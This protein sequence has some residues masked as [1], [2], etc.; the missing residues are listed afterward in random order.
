MIVLILIVISLSFIVLVGG[1]ITGIT[2]AIVKANKKS[3][4]TADNSL[5]CL[6]N[7]QLTPELREKVDSKV[8]KKNSTTIS[9][10]RILKEFSRFRRDVFDLSGPRINQKTVTMSLGGERLSFLRYIVKDKN[11]EYLAFPLMEGLLEVYKISDRLNIKVE[12]QL[13]ATVDIRAGEVLKTGGTVCGYLRFPQP[14][15]KS[16]LNIEG[17]GSYQ[18]EYKNTLFLNNRAACHILPNKA[19]L[20]KLS[21]YMASIKSNVVATVDFFSGLDE[22]LT[23]LEAQIALAIGLDIFYNYGGGTLAVSAEVVEERDCI[24]D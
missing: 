16:P 13:I 23:N 21:Q 8:V 18:L 20:T 12:E 10:Q 24:I 4:V 9:T 2:V 17:V 1:I 22:N 14:A 5:N 15:P 11:V 7:L 3:K 6:L 19:Q